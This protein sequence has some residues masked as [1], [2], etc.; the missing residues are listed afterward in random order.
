[1]KGKEESP[2]IE[3][4]NLSDMEFK[5]IVIRMLKELR[6]SRNFMGTMKNSVEITSV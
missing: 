4:S 6:T 3:A 2:E 1:M 5:V